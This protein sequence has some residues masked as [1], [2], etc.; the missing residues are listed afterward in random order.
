MQPNCNSADAPIELRSGTCSRA[1]REP[2]ERFR[3]ATRDGELPAIRTSE[4]RRAATLDS[5]VPWVRRRAEAQVS[6]VM[7]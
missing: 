1:T 2:R 5:L 4:G 7:A 3:A 6:Q